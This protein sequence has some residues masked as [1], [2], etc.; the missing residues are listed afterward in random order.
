MRYK[1]ALIST[2]VGVVALAAGVWLGFRAGS[3]DALH[4]L[5]G[6][7]EDGERREFALRYAVGLDDFNGIYGQD[8]WVM[9]TVFPKVKN[10]FFVD[11]GSADGTELSNTKRLEAAGWSGVCIDPFPRNMEGRTC[12]TFD[13]AVDSEGGRAVKF[14]SP[15]TYG[16]G[17]ADYAGWWVSK[18]DKSKMVDLTTTTIGDV[19]KRAGAPNFIHYMNVDIEGAEYEALKA[20]PFDRYKI[21]A[22]TVEHNNVEDRR[23]KLRDLFES[24]GYRLE[25]AIRDQ[26]WYVPKA[27]ANGVK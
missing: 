22:I 26:D 2:V 16:G 17:I 10:G 15:G 9:H 6:I 13:E 3:V 7:S 20:F 19:L 25:W 8:L 23:I 24:N 27:P 1:T 21:G 18:G 12:K 14:R 5:I 4:S 11:I